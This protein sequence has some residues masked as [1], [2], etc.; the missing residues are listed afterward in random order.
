MTPVTELI[1]QTKTVWDRADKTQE[2][3]EKLGEGVVAA[4]HRAM[5]AR[6]RHWDLT[7]KAEQEY[8]RVGR[9]LRELRER[10][11]HGKWLAT[12]KKIG[13]SNQRAGEL[14]RLAGG[15]E[16]ME[17]QR[18]RSRKSSEKHRGKFPSPS[19]GDGNLPEPEPREREPAPRRLSTEQLWVNVFAQTAAE[20]VALDAQW[21]RDYGDWRAYK[22]PSEYQELARQ[23]LETWG[24]ITNLVCRKRGNRGNGHDDK[25]ESNGHDN[26]N[27]QNSKKQLQA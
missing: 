10:V 27:H 25:V 12:L 4:E 14:M 24:N 11:G 13:R 2:R 1:K 17:Q 5:L 20:I 3:V 9:M 8:I 26:S 21:Q 23:A 7:K 22:V 16:T 6:G 18:E 15:E 19:S